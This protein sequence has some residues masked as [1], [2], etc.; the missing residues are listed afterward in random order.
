MLKHVN[1]FFVP[2]LIMVISLMLGYVL[3]M[4]HEG[5]IRK[6][7]QSQAEKELGTLEEEF[8]SSWKK[9]RTF[10]IFNGRFEVYPLKESDKTFCYKELRGADIHDQEANLSKGAEDKKQEPTNPE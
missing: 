7:Y 6:H 10:Y 9:P 1:K 5:K 3:R 8:H 4:Y 2:I